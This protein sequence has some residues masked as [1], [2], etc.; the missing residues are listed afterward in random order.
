MTECWWRDEDTGDLELDVSAVPRP[1]RFDHEEHGIHHWR[2]VDFVFHWPET[3]ELWLV[4]IKDPD[5]PYVQGDPARLIEDFKQKKLIHESLAPKAKDTFLYLLLDDELPAG[6]NITYIV[7]FACDAFSPA[8]R[9][10]YYRTAADELRRALG[11]RGPRGQG[12]ARADLYIKD[13]LIL[14]L[15]EWVQVLGDRVKARRLSTV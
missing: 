2:K 13:C 9:A 7:L 6:T 4:E 1:W 15:H 12:W 10:K 11:L 14:S 3:K 5:N 8:K